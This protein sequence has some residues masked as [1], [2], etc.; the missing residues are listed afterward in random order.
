[1]TTNITGKDGGCSTPGGC[2]M[3]YRNDGTGRF[4]DGTARAG[5]GDTAWGWGV[6]AF[7]ADLD[8]H[9]DL[10]AVNGWTQPPWHT[11]A[12]FFHADGT[13]GFVD[14]SEPSG[15]AHVG[16]TRSLVPIDLEGDGD[17]DFLVFDVLGPVT[18]YRNDTP[19]GENHW[20][21]VEAIGRRSNRD[22]VGARI[23]V[24][25]G[26][27][28]QLGVITVGGSFYAGPPLESHFGL[29]PAA[30]V[31][32]LEV[33]FPSG[34]VAV[35]TEIAADQRVRV[36]EPCPAD[37]DGSGLVGF[38]D[39]LTLLAAWG[40]CGGCSADLDGDGMVGPDDLARLLA[41]WGSC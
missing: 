18:V 26:G 33:R 17:T 16:N 23:E 38:G 27:R 24:T 39:L 1:Y 28:T 22:G 4:T 30:T 34:R 15:L 10:Y 21:I 13:G 8:G 31:D 11:P 41:D 14:A 19:R 32:R 25:A 40:G 2:N 5:I 20:L 37:L 29:G 6:W 12:V 7:D 35:L 9:R 3:F 36:I